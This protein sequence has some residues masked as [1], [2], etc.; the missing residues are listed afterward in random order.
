M[1]NYTRSQKSVVRSQKAFSCRWLV[2]LCGLLAALCACAPD[3]VQKNAQIYVTTDPD[4]ATLFYDSVSCG[5]TPATIGPIAAGEHLL[6]IRK[7][8]YRE[9]RKTLNVRSGERLAVE[10]SL[11]PLKGLVLIHSTP[12]GA[13]VE[14]EGASIGKT[15]LLS[16]DFPSGEKRIQVSKPGYLPKSVNVNVEDRTPLKVDL[17]L[18]SDSAELVVDSSPSGAAVTL[19]NSGI[20][21]TPLI[22]SG[23]KTGQHKLEI[24]LQGH[25]PVQHEITLQAGEKKKISSTLKSL[26]GKLNILSRPSKA[27]IYMNDQL[28]GETP[29]NATNIPSGKY[30]IRAELLGYDP[31]VL[32]NEVIFGGEATM[33][34]QLVKCSGTLLIT[35]MPPGVNIYIDGEFRGTTK[36]RGNELISEQLPIDFIPR[37]RHQLQFT[38]KG[39]YDV[40]RAIEI[41]PKQT[42]IVHEK[43]GLRPVPFVPNVIIRTGD[44]PEDSFRGIIREKFPNGDLKVEINPGIFKTFTKDEIVA[45]E[46]IPAP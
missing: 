21:K 25:T 3:A 6:T 46:P 2:G 32:T 33:E 24:S 1:K 38:K 26:P 20:G 15:P 43:I 5:A 7:A 9:M 39:Y 18:T 45:L 4:G 29:F 40:Q 22:L 30:V 41:M 19:D 8:G 31:Q 13:D 28:K 16:S 23:V 27:R 44:K 35:T 12:P 42:L 17:N 11:E 36:E 10:L 14:V 34:F 37:G